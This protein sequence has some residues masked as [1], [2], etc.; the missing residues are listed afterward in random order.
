V[1]VGLPHQGRQC[2]R[3][4][5][6]AIR[7]KVEPP[8]LGQIG[9]EADARN[10]REQSLW[11]FRRDCGAIGKPAIP[12]RRRCLSLRDPPILTLPDKKKLLA[13]NE[14]RKTGLGINIKRSQ[15]NLPLTLS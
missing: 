11:L 1:R 8:H 5:A 14:R 3:D 9:R 15:I 7:A 13:D 6:V 12:A 2:C 10:C 4:P